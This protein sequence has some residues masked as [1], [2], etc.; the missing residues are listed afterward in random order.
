MCEKESM[1]CKIN[2][3]YM[4]AALE[5]EILLASSMNSEVEV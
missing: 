5:S 3:E 1:N 2:S 4:E